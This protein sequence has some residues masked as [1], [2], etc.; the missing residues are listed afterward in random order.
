MY[1]K[2]STIGEEIEKEVGHLY[3]IEYSPGRE[4]TGKINV[5]SGLKSFPLKDLVIIEKA[6]QNWYNKI[7]EIA[8][9]INRFYLEY[10]LVIL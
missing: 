6:K 2:K 7:K 5:S 10:L 9:N 4:I 3:E 8:W 1:Y